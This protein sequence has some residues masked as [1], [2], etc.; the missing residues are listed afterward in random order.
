MNMKVLLSVF[1]GLCAL[2][3]FIFVFYALLST[4]IGGDLEDG[5]T[6]TPIAETRFP[7]VSDARL[8]LRTRDG[9]ELVVADIRQGKS[10]ERSEIFVEEGPRYVFFR[11]APTD[12]RGY[13]LLFVENAQEFLITLFSAPLGETRSL[14]EEDFIERLD[15]SEY[16]ACRLKVS[17]R[18]LDSIDP[19]YREKELGLSFCPGSVSL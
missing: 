10:V 18:A 11:S 9:V 3:G 4:E 12:D 6:N 5:E 1:F 16:D 17:V 19:A 14:A 8:P 7:V 15:I 13:Q 2:G